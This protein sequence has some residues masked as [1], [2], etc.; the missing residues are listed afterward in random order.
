[1]IGKTF[2]ASAYNLKPR[3]AI[4]LTGKMGFNI[5]AIKQLKIT[6]TCGI[7]L[8]P[9]T[10]DKNVLYLKVVEP[11]NEEAFSPKRSGDYFYINT[12]SLFDEID[13]DYAKMTYIY[14]IVR[15]DKYDEAIGGECYKL[16]G[17][18]KPRNSASEEQEEMKQE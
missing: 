17:R 12:K 1:M 3:A 7:V 13:L 10:A 9:D 18:P 5:D 4:Q 11:C 15:C 2:N 14:D 8:A 6:A 16:K